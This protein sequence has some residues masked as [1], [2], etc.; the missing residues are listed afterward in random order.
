MTHDPNHQQLTRV[1]TGA[2]FVAAL[3]QSGGSTPATLAGYGIGPDGYATEE[4][5]FDLAHAMRSR[6]IL[7]P[8]FDRRY[9]IG[10]ILFADTLDR[11]V[12]GKK[13]A[14]YLWSTKGI[15]PFLKI[16]KGLEGVQDGVRRMKP[17][18]DLDATLARAREAGI[19][20]TKARSFIIEAKSEGIEAIV[21]Q[22]FSLALRV[23]DA[24]LVPILEPEIDIHSPEREKAEHLL[25]DALSA[26]LAML[27]P[28]QRV[29]LKLSIPVL[30]NYYALFLGHPNVLRIL[31]LSGGYTRA[32]AVTA[33]RR[34][35]G[36]IASFARAFFEGLSVSQS[37]AEFDSTLGQ[38]VS[39]I[40]GA[41]VS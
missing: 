18:P 16:D 4:Q 10:T 29:I 32:Q 7:S 5:M 23:I 33:L 9:V 35:H 15:V 21:E 3:D 38:A 20:G 6:I 39:E 24:G 30:D 25:R 36:M 8:A 41:S 31:A 14:D 17:I 12:G 26:R 13:T 27:S 37:A 19:F 11:E 2:G 22:Q 28:A 34:N 40:Y 1:R